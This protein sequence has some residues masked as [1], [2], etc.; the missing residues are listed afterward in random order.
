M[1]FEFPTIYDRCE[2]D[3]HCFPSPFLL[4]NPFIVYLFPCSDFLFAIPPGGIVHHR[5]RAGR[6][7]E[8][9]VKQRKP[10]VYGRAESILSESLCSLDSFLVLLLRARGANATRKE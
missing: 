3:R 2:Y 7:A 5:G 9:R 4:F 1:G 10:I 6:Q 8:R